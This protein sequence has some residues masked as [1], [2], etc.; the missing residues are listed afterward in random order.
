MSKPI[1]IEDYPRI[2]RADS[3]VPVGHTAEVIIAN[4]V[5]KSQKPDPQR[6]A[7]AQNLC[8][9]ATIRSEL[10]AIL[11]SGTDNALEIAS[12]VETD[13]REFIT[14]YAPKL[15]GKQK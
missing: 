2:D 13:V 3:F 5:K 8:R 15:K 12:I 4:I 1:N 11:E 7:R 9:H 10:Q 6:L 14:V